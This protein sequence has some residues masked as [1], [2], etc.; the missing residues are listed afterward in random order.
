MITA[1]G[2]ET[3]IGR[4]AQRLMDSD[5]ASKTPLQRSIDRLAMFLFVFAVIVV[6]VIFAIS[7]FQLDD[8]DILYAITTAIAAVPEGLLAVLT[9][10][11]AFGVHAM[12]KANALVRRLV[13]LELLGSVTNI[14]SDKTGTLTQSKMVMTRFWRPG[15]GFHSVSGLGFTTE[16]EATAE[17]TN[18]PVE[19]TDAMKQFIHCAALCNMSDVQENEQVSGDPTEIALQVFAHKMKMGKP[20][21]NEKNWSM[22]AEYPFD[23]TIK[24][25]S[26][27][28]RTPDGHHVAF[29][30]GATE[31]M[32]DRCGGILNADNEVEYMN[33]SDMQALILPQVEALARCGLRV[34]TL[35]YRPVKTDKDVVDQETFARDFIERDM[36][37]LGLAGIYDPPREESKVAVE[38]CH[39]AGIT[40]HMLTGDH[41]ATATAIAREVSILPADYGLDKDPEKDGLVM[42][43]QKFDKLS[44]EQ[45]DALPELPLV[46]GRCSPET[47]VKVIEALYRRR[48]ISA[49]TG[50]GVNDSPSLKEAD[51]G[52]AM[53]ETGSDVAKQASDII[54]VDD[55]F[56]TIVHAIEEGRRVFANI[57]RFCV[58]LITANVALA[59]LLIV[60]LAFRDSTGKAAFAL[61]PLQILFA[62]CLTT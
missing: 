15:A 35:V 43:A 12:A 11:Q 16:G 9:L 40:V 50:D 58:H 52:I 25:M 2:M 23:S 57:S 10:T 53:G 36:I 38:R 29:G 17:E 28:M 24:R 42:S 14:C 30:K 7:K 49:M 33:V 61:S 27:L 47:K 41:I 55:N 37:F 8:Q 20:A 19:M 62:N 34:L 39:R 21:L 59:F 4:I 26:V 6:I 60:G 13:S 44:E 1:I 5:D 48:K 3:E 54:L 31:R 45:I 32:L 51:V 56:S 18:T 46:I 22:A